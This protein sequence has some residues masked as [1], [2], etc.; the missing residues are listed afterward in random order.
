ME[1]MSSN[2]RDT[3]LLENV[4]NYWKAFFH[5]FK[6]CEFPSFLVDDKPRASITTE[7][8]ERAFQDATLELD[9]VDYSAIQG[10]CSQHQVTVSSLFQ[11]AWAVVVASFASVEDVSFGYFENSDIA[12]ENVVLI[13][14]SQIIA[15]RTLG[16]I[17]V[18]MMGHL[19]DMR[20][21]YQ[22]NPMKISDVQKLVGLEGQPLFN[23][24]LRMKQNLPE[25]SRIRE[26]N[27]GCFDIL[28][29]V[30]INDSGSIAVTIRT[31]TSKFSPARTTSVADTFNKLLIECLASGDP[32][33]FTVGDLDTFTSCDHDKVM[34]WNP[35]LPPAVDACF[36]DLFEQVVQKSPDAPAIASWCGH[37][38]TYRELDIISIKLANYLVNEV[39][40]VVPET[41]VLIC[42]DKSSIAMVSMLG[43]FKAGG[44]FVAID[45]TYPASRIQAIAQATK[46][47]LVLVQS[48]HRDIF[49]EIFEKE[50]IIT[51]DPRFL[52][53][54][55][56]PP[57][58]APPLSLAKP[59]NVAY[60]HFTSGSTGTPKGILIEHRALCTAVS[61]LATPMRISSTSRVLQFASYVFDLSFGD[62]FVTL[63][64]G[65]CICVPS[66]DERLND[67]AEA[68]IRMDVNTACLIPSV[69][70]VL[71]PEDVPGLQTLLLGG[72]ALLQ[73][74][75]ECWA[76]KVVLT[77]MYGPSECTVWCSSQT[78]MRSDSL[79]NNIGRGRGARLWIA[80]S[81][82]HDRLVPVGC[83]GELLIEGPLLARGY[84]NVK[85][86][87]ESFIE[88][89]I[90][91][92]SKTCPS[93]QRRFYKT[94]DLAKFNNDGTVSFIGRKDTQ[95]KLHGRRIELGEIEHH[96]AS[97]SL[98][99][100]SLVMLSSAGVHAKR[101]V[102][103]IV[104]LNSTT[105]VKNEA[106]T[107]ITM[108]S[109]A[110]EVA[111]IKDYLSSALPTYMVPQA[112]VVLQDIPLMISGKMDRMLVGKSVDSL[113]M[114]T[115]GDQYKKEES[116]PTQEKSPFVLN[117]LKMRPIWWDV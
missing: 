9:D 59:S 60:I 87:K 56:L 45:P 89:P 64:Q 51:V 91:A 82:D 35:S 98:V 46:A 112:W 18:D 6:P 113:I 85:Q 55:P 63:S 83:I 36:H 115:R 84:L 86:T 17:M 68:I 27:E 8:Q 42:F 15:G 109:C 104:L 39:G 29:Q 80:R 57:A 37:D 94:G 108:S 49:K 13:C 50:R 41:A 102:A 7:S 44:A 74:N 79:A 53:G 1:S 101:L 67:L 61:V 30:S 19:K 47:S 97:N 93:H 5:D 38:Y 75:L 88:N 4:S 20:A 111:K 10:F 43:I 23:S 32:Q 22:E 107:L 73:E 24:A 90:W 77:S 58:T 96:L 3:A 12:T 95:I 76:D 11:T 105:N 69:A 33:S 26:Q 40:L 34:S 14:R 16:Q 31:D 28:A 72:E 48:S 106:P 78:N 81:D 117:A 92:Q 103:V 2:D 99:R 100:Q 71:D 52:D 62:I 70:C 110:S 25:Q 66:E 114:M 116:L 65:G 21:C 54:L